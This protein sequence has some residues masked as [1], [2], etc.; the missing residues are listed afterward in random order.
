MIY[1]LIG[2]A[3]LLAILRIGYG[4]MKRRAR[5]GRRRDRQLEDSERNAAWAE[6]MANRPDRIKAAPSEPPTV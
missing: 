5:A 3:A 4:A 2:A 6:M 1:W